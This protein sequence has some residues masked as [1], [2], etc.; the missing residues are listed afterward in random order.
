MNAPIQ[1]GV[2]TSADEML[3]SLETY[4]VTVQSPEE[5]RAYLAKYPELIQHVGRVGGSSG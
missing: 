1:A 3:R 4:R 5:V 2:E